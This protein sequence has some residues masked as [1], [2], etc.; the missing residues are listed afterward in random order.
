MHDDVI[1]RV[2]GGALIR[3]RIEGDPQVVRP[4]PVRALLLEE[5]G[6]VGRGQDD[7]VRH[8]RARAEVEPFLPMWSWST[9]TFSK[10]LAVS[11]VTPTTA[12]SG[13]GSRSRA[14]QI[15]ATA[16]GAPMRPRT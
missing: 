15:I 9:P 1:D 10:R 4:E 2:V 3:I 14:E 6:A 13:T 8:E 7:T 5:V 16:S 12:P 11:S